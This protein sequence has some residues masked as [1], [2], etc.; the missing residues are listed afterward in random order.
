MFSVLE[1]YAPLYPVNGKGEITAITQTL[2]DELFSVNI[3]VSPSGSVQYTIALK[4]AL[5]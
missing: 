4:K 3:S 5:D 2:E 1:E